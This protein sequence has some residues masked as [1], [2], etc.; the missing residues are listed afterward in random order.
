LIVIDGVHGTI[1]E[2]PAQDQPVHLLPPPGPDGSSETE[3]PSQSGVH[4]TDLDRVI[5]NTRAVVEQQHHVMGDKNGPAPN[6]NLPLSAPA[7]PAAPSGGSAQ[8]P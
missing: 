4:Q 2:A 1:P 6:Y 7:G 3:A 8:H 5:Q